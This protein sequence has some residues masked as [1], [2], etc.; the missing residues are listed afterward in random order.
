MI[1][2]SL[3][4]PY[5]SCTVVFPFP[6]PHE[7]TSSEIFPAEPEGITNLRT[8]YLRQISFSARVSG[9]QELDIGVVLYSCSFAVV[10]LMILAQVRGVKGAV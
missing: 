3:H 8:E 4:N 2:F 7:P 9:R 10:S 5:V 6:S 1:Y